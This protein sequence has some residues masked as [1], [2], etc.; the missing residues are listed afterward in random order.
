MAQQSRGSIAFLSPPQLLCR[1]AVLW[2]HSEVSARVQALTT[3]LC[4][5]LP[6]QVPEPKLDLLVAKFRHDDMPEMVNYIA[7]ANTVAPPA[8]ADQPPAATGTIAAAH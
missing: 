6:P 8:F 1:T 3:H 5:C 2:H 4:C 7:F